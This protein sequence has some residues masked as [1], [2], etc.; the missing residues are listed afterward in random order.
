MLVWSKTCSPTPALHIHALTNHKTLTNTTTQTKRKHKKDIARHR[1]CTH[2]QYIWQSEAA[3][4]Q[5]EPSGWCFAFFLF[6]LAIYTTIHSVAMQ[7]ERSRIICM[8]NVCIDLHCWWFVCVCVMP[9]KQ[10]LVYCWKIEIGSDACLSNLP[11]LLYKKNSVPHKI[12]N[13]PSTQIH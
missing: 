3:R 5:I 9:Y 1:S 10:P 12:V 7:R 13:T 4:T 2:R 6:W 8:F 11:D